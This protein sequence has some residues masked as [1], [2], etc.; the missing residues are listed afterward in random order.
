MCET[1]SG[2]S[3]K[4]VP[5]GTLESAVFDHNEQNGDLQLQYFTYGEENR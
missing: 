4:Y 3:P 2:P 1:I 5:I